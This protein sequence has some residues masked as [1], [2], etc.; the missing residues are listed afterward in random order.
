MKAY[1]GALAAVCLL[2]GCN[3]AVEEAM[4]GAGTEYYGNISGHDTVTPR[5]PVN[6]TGSP[7]PQDT[8][9]FGGAWPGP[10]GRPDTVPPPDVRRAQ[11]EQR[12]QEEDAQP[13]QE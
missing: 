12:L 1:L 6:I 10:E 9:E 8:I 13:P 5:E 11:Q 2:A 7:P 4:Q 3:P